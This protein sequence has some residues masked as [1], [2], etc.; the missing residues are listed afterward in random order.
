MNKPNKSVIKGTDDN[1][2]TQLSFPINGPHTPKH[3]SG[4]RQGTPYE[5]PSRRPEV[6]DE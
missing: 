6:S 5:V 2:P 3:N 1:T 4:K